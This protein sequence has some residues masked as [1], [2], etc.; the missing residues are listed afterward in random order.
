MITLGELKSIIAEAMYDMPSRDELEQHLL[1]AKADPTAFSRFVAGIGSHVPAQGKLLLQALIRTTVEWAKGKKS[2]N[3]VSK[4]L[5]ALYA[6][7]N[8]KRRTSYAG[9]QL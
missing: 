3:E 4:S 8:P 2:Y 9:R 5:D 1:Y 6:A 7:L